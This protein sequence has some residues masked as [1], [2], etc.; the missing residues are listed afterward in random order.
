MGCGCEV[1]TQNSIIY[2]R[3]Q[4]GKRGKNR[5]SNWLTRRAEETESELPRVA[6]KQANGKHTT[7]VG[8]QGASGSEQRFH[9]VI[10]QSAQPADGGSG[11]AKHG[12]S[13]WNCSRTKAAKTK[14]KRRNER[15]HASEADNVSGKGVAWRGTH[16][17]DMRLGTTALR[18]R[19]AEAR[20]ERSSHLLRRRWTSNSSS[21]SFLDSSKAGRRRNKK[22]AG[23]KKKEATNEAG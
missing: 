2:V 4:G 7:V 6:S 18:R 12:K 1:G 15:V 17:G 21:L 22:T 11:A 3:S 5:E 13:G 23:R 19:A 20:A 8:G 16:H 14:G 9:E 10:L